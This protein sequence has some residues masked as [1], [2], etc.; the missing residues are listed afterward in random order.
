MET[1]IPSLAALGIAVS[2]SSV[3]SLVAVLILLE[4]PGGLRRAVAF[5]AGWVAMIAVITLAL[6]LF[7]SLDFRTSSSTPSRISSG[8]EIAIGALLVGWAAVLYR[9][10]K[11]DEPKDPI[12]GWLTRLLT[13]SWMLS[14]AA[15]ALMLT[16]SITV[17][18]AL[19][20]LKAHV[21]RLDWALAMLVYAV[22]SVVVL[23]APMIYAAAAPERASATLRAAKRWLTLNWQHVSAILLAGIGILIM[24]KAGVDIR[25]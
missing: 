15:G 19:E 3:A 6:E 4:L 7:P 5:I 9:R 20:V 22:A 13:R 17:V 12:P 23:C 8:A 2:V 14:A 1:L 21:G 18:A 24:C 11:P 10:P 16:Y 25:S